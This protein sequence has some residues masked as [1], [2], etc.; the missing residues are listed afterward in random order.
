MVN[1]KMVH[2]RIVFILTL[3]FSFENR[4]KILRGVMRGLFLEKLNC[5]SFKRLSKIRKKS[6]KVVT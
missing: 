6:D 5:I 1:K 4:T 3:D 2:R